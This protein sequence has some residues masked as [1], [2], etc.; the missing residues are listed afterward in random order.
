MIYTVTLNPA[1]DKEYRVPELLPNKILRASS[2]K[3]DFG[4]K[5]FNIARMLSTFDADCAALGFIGGHTGSILREGLKSNGIKTDFVEISGE[6]RTNISAVSD[7]DRSYVKINEAGPEILP[8]EIEQLLQKVEELIHP[9]DWWIMSGS[10]PRGVPHDIY[11]QMIQRINRGKARAILDSSGEALNY[12]CMA[13]PFLIKP[14][15]EELTHITDLNVQDALALEE[16]LS[17]IHAMGVKNIILSAGKEKAICS[18]GNQRWVGIPP[19]VDEINPIGAGDAMLAAIVYRLS[20]EDSLPEAFRWGLAAGS[21]AAS[22][23]GTMMP[24]LSDVEKLLEKVVVC[25]E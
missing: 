4:G 21:V 17:R 18:N 10:L 8:E 23:P 9:E 2:V 25:E 20:R 22:L 24:G 5:G 3:I 1:L 13:K 19:K 11:A 14:N 15:V 16:A 12:G 6:T 7:K